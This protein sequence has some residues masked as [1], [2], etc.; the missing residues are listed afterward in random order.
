MEMI[1][2]S[3]TNIQRIEVEYL[4][5]EAEKKKAAPVNSSPVVDTNTLPA[6][7]PLP[8]PAPTPSGTSS[9]VSSDTPGSSAATLPPRSAVLAHYADRPAARLEASILGMIQTTLTDVVTPLSATIDPLT[10]RISVCEHSQGATEEVTALKAAIV[11]L[12]RGVD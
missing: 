3:Y 4:K 6:E 9:L 1:P 8:T 10:T 2:T 12:R 7:E 11:A 5:H